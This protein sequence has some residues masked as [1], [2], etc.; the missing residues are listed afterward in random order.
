MHLYILSKIYIVSTSL[1]KL[2]F[3]LSDDHLLPR[4]KDFIPI[5]SWVDLQ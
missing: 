2:K 1:H 4:L 5:Y 3:S